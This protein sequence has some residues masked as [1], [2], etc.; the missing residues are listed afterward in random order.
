MNIARA[1][2]FKIRAISFNFEKEQGRP[3][4]H[5]PPPSSYAPA[6]RAII[7]VQFHLDFVVNGK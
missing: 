4:P 2:F 5:L 3:P 1:F 6:E 7:A